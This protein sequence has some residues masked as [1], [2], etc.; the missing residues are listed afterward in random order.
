MPSI[1]ASGGLRYSMGIEPTNPNNRRNTGTII[2]GDA[3]R[4]ARVSVSQHKGAVHSGWPP[5]SS[6][7]AFRLSSVLAMTGGVGTPSTPRAA[8]K[9]I[10]RCAQGQRRKT[11]CWLALLTVRNQREARHSEIIVTV[12]GDQRRAGEQSRGRNPGI[13]AINPPAACL[14]RDGHLCPLRT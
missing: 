8:G 2:I 5:V 11:G 6:L 3:S 12:V 13:R 7:P 14:S 4:T 1:S 10:A 9:G